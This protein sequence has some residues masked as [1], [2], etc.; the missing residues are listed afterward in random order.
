MPTTSPRRLNSGPP[1]LPGLTATSVWIN[2]TKFSCGSD[3]PFALT[4]PAVTVLSNPNGEPIATTH[5]PTFSFAGSPKRTVGRL[6][7]SILISAT[8]VRL[9]VPITLALNSRLS[10][11]LT[12]TSSAPSIT[13]ALVSMKPSAEMMN[14]EPNDCGWNSRC[15]GLGEKRRKNSKKGSFSSICGNCWE[16]VLRAACVMLILTTAPPCF[17]TRSVKSGNCADTCSGTSR[18]SASIIVLSIV[19]FPGNEMEIGK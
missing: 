13:W 12:V 1:E 19:V 9:S 8:S 14:P 6:A 17:S 16:S 5:S 2:G 10:I 4:I 18:N 15:P 11:S 3:R 7:A